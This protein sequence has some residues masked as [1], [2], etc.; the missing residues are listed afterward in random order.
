MVELPL[1]LQTE[2]DWVL[3]QSHLMAADM[4]S[5]AY[6]DATSSQSLFV[7]ITTLQDAQNISYSLS[8]VGLEIE[9]SSILVNSLVFRQALGGTL[10]LPLSGSITVSDTRTH[11]ISEH[12]ITTTGPCST[13]ARFTFDVL[14]GFAPACPS[15][16]TELS[17]DGSDVNITWTTPV[18][19]SLSGAVHTLDTP[20]ESP[21]L[22]GLGIWQVSYSMSRQDNS[23]SW[24]A[25]PTCSFYVR[26]C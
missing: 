21:A 15:D 8:Q 6:I 5:I 20:V 17:L 4:V 9:G 13:T 24:S 12:D 14:A 10:R 2:F 11:C 26:L 19:R 16:M 7:A 1:L 3:Q 22:F 25:R 23:Q 18:L